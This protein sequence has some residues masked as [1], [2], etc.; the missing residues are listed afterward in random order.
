LKQG[1]VAENLPYGPST[2]TAGSTSAYFSTALKNTKHTGF[3][4]VFKLD[5]STTRFT[6]LWTFQTE[7]TLQQRFLDA[8]RSG[9]P[10]SWVVT[11]GGTTH[12]YSGTWWFSIGANLASSAFSSSWSSWSRFSADDGIWGAGNGVL[13]GDR[14][15]CTSKPSACPSVFDLSTTGGWG[16]QNFDSGDDG[17]F[18]ESGVAYSGDSRMR[19][20]MY[21]VSGSG[22]TLSPSATPAARCPTVAPTD[23]PTNVPTPPTRSPTL[24]KAGATCYGV[25][26]P[27]YKTFDNKYFAFNG[28]GRFYMVK[29]TE[30]EIQA[31]LTQTP[32]NSYVTFTSG[33]AFA[34]SAMQGSRLQIL[35][36]NSGLSIQINGSSYT[37]G[38][39]LPT[40]SIVPTGSPGSYSKVVLTVVSLGITV[41]IDN[42][43]YWFFAY[44]GLNV[45]VS[46]AGSTP[47]RADSLSC[48]CG[49]LDGNS[50][51]DQPPSSTGWPACEVAANASVFPPSLSSAFVEEE[52]V[53]DDTARIA[54]QAAADLCLTN[55]TL[56]KTATDLCA[57]AGSMQGACYSDMCAIGGDA[58]SQ[59]SDGYQTA[60]ATST[61]LASIAAGTSTWTPT[62]APTT[63][64][65]SP[66][67]SATPTE[68][69]TLVPSVLPSLTPTFP[70]HL[71]AA[72][73]VP[74]PSPAP[75]PAP[76]DLPTGIPKWRPP[77]PTPT[78]PPTDLPT[79]TPSNTPT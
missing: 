5:G 49:N 15:Q 67:P 53:L 47:Y 57:S 21:L 17:T 64:S 58:A 24:P 55:A 63:K 72:P 3:E 78:H 65:P 7:K 38:Q 61:E 37:H 27:N 54:M 59:I 66:S 10:V 31:L 76:T 25:G 28:K 1:E 56:N 75:S 32:S 42:V 6:I 51:N 34:G 22:V 23:F 74:R 79:R 11:K 20:E 62:E 33:L 9:E 41:Q 12:K 13:N 19:T 77:T 69:P 71:T 70:D 46:L 35:G 26:D 60:L 68:F 48:L 4:Q 50:Y 14:Q 73:C 18:Y 43:P 30:L 40:M 39:Q 8:T 29:S 52:I 36:G 44:K 16:V 45:Y 2:I